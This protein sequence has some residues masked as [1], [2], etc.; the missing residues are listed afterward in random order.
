MHELC[1]GLMALAHGICL[2]I[3]SARHCG[4]MSVIISADQYPSSFTAI[5]RMGILCLCVSSRYRA[6]HAAMRWHICRVSGCGKKFLELAYTDSTIYHPC[7]VPCVRKCYV[8]QR[9]TWLPSS[10]LQILHRVFGLARYCES[11]G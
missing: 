4:D 6:V 2:G 11:S 10:P 3:G 7:V 9:T 8:N 5:L 1:C